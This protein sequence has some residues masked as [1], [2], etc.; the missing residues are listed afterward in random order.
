MLEMDRMLRP[1]GRVYILDKVS[2]IGELKEIATALGWFP[3]LRE[4]A[5]GPHSSW[6]L[7]ICDKRM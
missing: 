6:R 1:D 2:V 4:T 5:D 3:A 7:L